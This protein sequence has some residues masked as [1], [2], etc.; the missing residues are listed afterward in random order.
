MWRASLWRVLEHLSEPLCETTHC[1]GVG[2]SAARV[3]RLWKPAHHNPGAVFL[4][5]L[6]PGGACF[7]L[8]LRGSIDCPHHVPRFLRSLA[9]QNGHSCGHVREARVLVLPSHFEVSS[10]QHQ[11]CAG[12]IPRSITRK[13]RPGAAN[14][15]CINFCAGVSRSVRSARAKHIV[16]YHSRAHVEKQNAPHPGDRQA[17]GARWE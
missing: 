2:R 9:H 5:V 16:S 7:P 15:W 13:S 10:E 14:D 1:L 11:T 4:P 12:P 17:R 6:E 3:F 8:Q